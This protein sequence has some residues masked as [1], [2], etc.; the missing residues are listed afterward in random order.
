M[1]TS[2]TKNQ[3]RILTVREYARIQSFPDWY[4]FQGNIPLVPRTQKYQDYTYNRKCN[5]ATFSEQS[6]LV[7]KQ[8]I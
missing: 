2:T 3:V 4:K 8:L 7:L 5:P 1:I 6:G